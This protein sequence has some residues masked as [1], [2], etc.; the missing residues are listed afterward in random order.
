[1]FSDRKISFPS[2]KQLEINMKHSASPLF[3]WNP[4]S[5]EN[6]ELQRVV[7]PP[8]VL[9]VRLDCSPEAEIIGAIVRLESA[10][11]LLDAQRSHFG[12]K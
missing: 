2:S 5:L 6:P 7:R 4:F 11:N 10:Q 12:S 1:M 3:V 9:L 8:F